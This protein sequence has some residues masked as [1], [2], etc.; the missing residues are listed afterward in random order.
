MRSKK[1]ERVAKR[2]FS[3]L[4]SVVLMLNF[5]PASVFPV[6]AA[7]ESYPD[8]FTITVTDGVNPIV[9]A[10]ISLGAKEEEWSLAL[11]GVTDANGVAAFATD[12][13]LQALTDAGMDAG[14]VV[15]TTEAAGFENVTG[16]IAVSQSDLAANIDISMTEIPPAPEM[17]TISVNIAR[18]NAIVKLNG[19]VQNSIT[20]EAGQ[21]VAIEITPEA[22]AFIHSLTVGGEAKE[23]ERGTAYSD[24]ITVSGEI[25]IEVDVRKVC[26]VTVTDVP[27][28]GTV[29]IG[30][31]EATSVTVDEGSVIDLVIQ[32]SEGY[33][34]DSVLIGN[35]H[36][37]IANRNSFEASPVITEDTTIT[38]TFMKVYT[39]TV[40]HNSNGTV[41]T[42][43]E[44]VGGSVIVENGENVTITADPDDHYRVLE[45]MIND[46]EDTSVT[47]QNYA[48][49]EVYTKVLEQITADYNVRVTFAP[50]RYEI[51]KEP[52]V[53]GIISLSTGLTEYNGFC[54][55]TITPNKGYSIS[56]I[57]V[58]DD[59]VTE[60]DED[61]EGVV[62]FTLQNIAGDMRVSATFAQTI[63]M[64]SDVRGLFNYADAVRATDDTFVFAKGQLITFSTDKTGIRIY[65]ENNRLIGGGKDEQ[66]FSLDQSVSVSKVQL[67]YQDAGE[68]IEKWHDVAGV[69]GQTPLRLI[70]DVVA[71]HLTVTPENRH[72]ND[73][74]N[75]DFKITISATDEGNYSGI[76][77][78][79]YFVTDTEIEGNVVYEEVEAVVKTQT[80]MIEPDTGAAESN[81][82]GDITVNVEGSKNNSDYVSVWF[83]VT[84]RAGN[85]E[86]VRTEYYRVYSSAPILESVIIDDIKHE[87]AQ[88]GYYN[89]ARTATIVIKERSSSF[90]AWWATECL[91]IV[92]TDKKGNPVSIDKQSMVTWSSEGDVHTGTIVFDRDARY[93][94]E[95]R[96]KSLAGIKLDD[97]TS[98]IETGENIYAFTV[99]TKAP[100]GKIAFNSTKIW[101]SL[102]TLDDLT[103]GVWSNIGFTAT[104]TVED[105][106]SETYDVL[107]YKAGADEVL[108]KQELE[109]LTFD[110]T[111]NTVSAE[112]KY[113]IYARITDYAGNTTYISTNG[114]IIDTT[115][116]S[117]VITPEPANDKGIHNKDVSVNIAVNEL[118]ENH[119]VYSGIQRI[120]YQIKT[121]GIATAPRNLFT[122]D[123]ENPTYEQLVHNWSGSFTVE[124]KKHNSDDVKVIVTVVDNAGNKYSEQSG[125]TINVDKVTASVEMNGT[126]G[127]IAD[128][129]GYYA[130]E[131]RTAT[132]TLTDRA[133][134]FNEANATKGIHITAVDRLDGD[135]V[136][137]AVEDAYE[138]SEW[139]SNGKIHTATITF[140]KDAFY[141]WS[142][143]YT[144]DAG[145][146]LESITTGAAQTP[147]TF[148]LDNSAPTGS[149][150]INEKT[151][152][153]LH[154]ALI[155]G[156]Y[157]DTKA[158]ISATASDNFTPVITEYYKTGRVEALSEEE[159]ERKPFTAYNDFSI[160]TDEQFV[161]Y[162]RLT[163][164]A[165]NTTYI[166]SDVYVVDSKKS[167]IVLTQSEED[168]LYNKES[169]AK[170]TVEVE[171]PTPYS[172]IKTIDYW[173]ERDTVTLQEDKLFTFAME[174][175]VQADLV[176]GWNGAIEINKEDCNSCNVRVHVR[177]EDNAGNVAEDVIALDID[178]SAP[179]ISVTF[180]SGKDVEDNIYFNTERTATI[181]VTERTH[182]FVW[183]QADG[184]TWWTAWENNG[185][186]NIKAVDAEN[187]EVENAYT[188]S[189]WTTEE[190]VNDPNLTTHTAT[191]TF[192]EDAYYEWSIAYTDKA[193][194]ENSE[195]TVSAE[196][197]TYA[198]AFKFY[199]DRVG[200]TG[201]VKAV[202][203]G[204]KE[205]T[206]DKLKS[207]LS[208]GFWSKDKIVISGTAKDSTSP[209]IQS[210][211]YFK[212]KK[213]STS[214]TTTALTV[215]ELDG[216]EPHKWMP[217]TMDRPGDAE[218]IEY[219]YSGLEITSDE[220][221]VVYVKLTDLA[222]N[223]TYI[224]TDAL[225]FDHNAPVSE[226]VAPE[227]AVTAERP[228]SGIYNGDVNVTIRVTEPVVG[229]SFSG[230][231]SVAYKVFREGTI[232]QNDDEWFTFDI[233]N[234]KE[235]DLLQTF[236][237]TVTIKSADNNSN[238]VKIVIYA[239]DNAMNTSEKELE[240]RIDTTAPVID[241][242][243]DNNTA[244]N[245]KY[246]KENRIA[247]VTIT[248]RNFNADDVKITMTSTDGVLPVIGEWQKTEGTGNKDNTTWRANIVYSADGDYT[249]GIAYSDLAGNP[250]AGASFGNSVAPTEFTIDK[251]LPVISVRYDN[252]N[253]SNGKYFANART[254]TVTITEHNFDANSV[255]FTRT[256]SLNGANI[257]L[258]TVS[259]REN[260]D[261]HTAT[262]VYSA[263]GDYT[264]DVSMTD[265][266][267]NESG[268]VDFG[269]SVAGKDFVVDRTI[270][271]PVIG[272]VEN[273]MAYIGEVI[274]TISFSD[275]N[276][277]SYEVMLVRTRMGKK[278]VN[279]TEQFITG[280]NELAKGGNG[281]YDTF[282]KIVENDG[283]YTLTVKMRDKAG[284]EEA[285]E[286]TFTINRFG[287]VYVYSD[288][289]AELIKDGG[290]YVKATDGNRYAIT[291]DL[292][293][294][295]Y[296][297]DRL[298]DDSLQILITRD[299][300][301]LD[302]D[303]TMTPVT[304]DREVTVGESGWYEYVY[305]IK[306]E[307]F[308]LDGAY[309]ISL[310]S[311]YATAD[312]A[313]NES[314]S[315]P[316][317]SMDGN[318]KQIV[319][320]MSF[321]VDTTAPEIRNIVNLDKRIPDVDKIVNNR[322][323]V[324]YTIVDVGGLKSV[325]IMLNGR[326][327]ES[328]TEF[329]DSLFS[330]SGSFDIAESNDTSAYKIQIVATDLAGNVTDTA[331][332][333]FDTKD[334]YVFSD[335]VIVSRNF[336]VRWYANTALFWGSIGGTVAV[337]GILI[338]L[339]ASKRKK[340]NE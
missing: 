338:Y 300:E 208:F 198:Q 34:I 96:Y 64:V 59:E 244:Y 285:S 107:Y 177:V 5:L 188:I 49:G 167:T 71:P 260:G 122:F 248:E 41:V 171:E 329:E 218:T 220:Q 42:N 128:G 18:G 45:V 204:G 8:S 330:Y 56:S 161:I 131:G 89:G 197:G 293:I 196:S 222:G 258:P 240:L 148:T 101:D 183:E 55:V 273:G 200:P 319:D 104:T 315:V 337:L 13:I 50:N 216:I 135:P 86:Y 173:I 243:Y 185:W 40:S 299:G 270:A 212:V 17:H 280:I 312:S 44:T 172:G 7:T 134:S 194:N 68:N 1:R 100:T 296:N 209:S 192:K 267:G 237:R 53:N 181:V 95:F 316:A 257:S 308:T 154:N 182:H 93:N 323:K 132:I 24:T 15:Y 340:D 146:A 318:G 19:E 116:G 66:S 81:Y 221:C 191:I 309:K 331:S 206:W 251:T 127:R 153:C 80:G 110:A 292:I 164:Y 252:N 46:E 9:G 22:G 98:L 235:N 242:T 88:A 297:A 207:E 322:L 31:N 238:D 159:L 230:I 37:T 193:G 163:D 73:Y 271:K 130:M 189:E 313:N 223:I 211:E 195:V 156:G 136:E 333:E 246:F 35:E 239:M 269:N 91:N 47:G 190:N 314:T 205:S 54:E 74:Y 140:I 166:S 25:A 254:A 21:A 232:S 60:F 186:L 336:F 281:S 224:S 266:A 52:T 279:V 69:S 82:T 228:A 76:G 289:L 114:A 155:V 326:L 160:D 157:S 324:S 137:N 213:Q 310:K 36:Q 103:F 77:S 141:T 123:V 225:I 112:G 121:D 275:E 259:W 97:E 295:E 10:N 249:F 149:V 328:I 262:I 147:F 125:L 170:V 51:I 106:M 119:E 79:E 178:T 236:S 174:A 282:K 29:T 274:P 332:K 58:G 339:I 105:E 305:T 325:D 108:G 16:E 250:C 126:P 180:D 111:S 75:D 283:I 241:V 151:W 288:Y 138:I 61:E 84:D 214:D 227:I 303:Y 48:N 265:I 65:D 63:Q 109:E 264:F 4:L 215:E 247:T 32:A 261:I 94:W 78:I 231:K 158:V 334:R 27:E 302:V 113:I 28:G 335:E 278:N 120:D 12:E 291:K 26:T 152:D 276:Y 14:T 168:A 290:R 150:T 3:V 226:I 301:A 57:H 304:V 287:S 317:N 33:Q 2:F 38:V 144:N 6:K 253:V 92:A 11:S 115:K 117:I 229:G 85:V 202:S 133:K 311:A 321:I 87:K 143:E 43:P 203:T 23:I 179:D 187:A 142:F 145:N 129:R 320:T 67:R 245:D 39:V 268:E 272:G 176:A 124:A 233:V 219:S 210:I 162:L 327:Y 306:A 286:V 139:T 217:F 30:G 256:A 169:E 263:D 102:L 70:I 234:P 165:G 298:L 277:D 20:V 72:Y 62:T 118:V 99:D 83:K 201:T 175:P 294:T 284:N 199:I 184:E 255:V 307:N 90:E